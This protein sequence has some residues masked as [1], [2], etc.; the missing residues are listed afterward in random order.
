[1]APLTEIPIFL[2]IASLW[3]GFCLYMLSKEAFASR[4]F[5]MPVSMEDP[6]RRRARHQMISVGI[7]V[8]AA[9]ALITFISAFL[10]DEMR[11][12]LWPA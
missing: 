2:H 6:R 7:A 4:R 5:T 11:R 8:L 10:P 1:M 9:L 12:G 3:W